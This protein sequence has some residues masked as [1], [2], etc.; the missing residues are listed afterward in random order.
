MASQRIRAIIAAVAL[1]SAIGQV[2]AQPQPGSGLDAK[3]RAL[4][5]E[6]Q[7]FFQEDIAQKRTDCASGLAPE[8]IAAKR[9]ANGPKIPFPDATNMCVNIL[10]GTAQDRRLGDLYASLMTT[11]LGK[12]DGGETLPR[13]IGA[14]VLRGETKVSIGAG[15]AAVVTPALAFDAGFTVAYGERKPPQGGKPNPQQLKTLAEACL[16]QQRDVG[17]CFSAGYMYGAQ[18][19][20]G[21]VAFP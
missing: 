10:M 21:Q 11:W 9:A 13:T 2:S 3:S 4:L 19:I 17:S 5:N 6:L 7:E 15:K 12:A 14:A 8:W 1:S 16:A 18:A 20:S